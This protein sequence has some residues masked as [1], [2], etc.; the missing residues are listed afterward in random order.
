M[1]NRNSTKLTFAAI[2]LGVLLFFI[3]QPKPTQPKP[4]S[5]PSPSVE[6]SEP[7]LVSTN[8]TSLEGT[9]V[10]PTQA[11]EL[12]FNQP[13]VNEPYTLIRLEP[14]MDFKVTLTNENKTVKITPAEN[15]K[16]GSGY[17][18]TVDSLTKFQG[19]KTLGQNLLFHFKTV[20]YSGV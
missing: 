12:T 8:P 17:T 9:T 11:I 4:A 2:G 20:S 14:E 3:F 16:F 6:S 15:Y 1:L 19:D 18:L 10:T 5:T 7:H 13:L